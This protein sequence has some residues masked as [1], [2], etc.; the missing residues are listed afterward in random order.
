MSTPGKSGNGNRKR[1]SSTGGA[2]GDEKFL[3]FSDNEEETILGQDILSSG[4]DGSNSIVLEQ[5][6]I[7]AGQDEEDEERVIILHMDIREPLST[8]RSLLE[9]RLG[10][11]DLSEYAIWLQDSQMLEAHK[12]LVDQ[13]VQGEGI[14]QVNVELL[15]DSNHGARINIVDVLKPGDDYLE[16]NDIEAVEAESETSTPNTANIGRNMMR[17]SVDP[18]FKKVQEKFNV[19]QGK[20]HLTIRCTSGST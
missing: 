18:H 8:L 10:G 6:E 20:Q 12:T 19:P 17:W 4:L 7:I 1:K 16:Q 5:G 11:V 2:A 14:V 15:H 3:R 9:E 13:C